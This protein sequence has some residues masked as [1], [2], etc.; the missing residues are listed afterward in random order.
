MTVDMFLFLDQGRI[1][2]AKAAA[3]GRDPKA[4]AWLLNERPNLPQDEDDNEGGNPMTDAPNQIA[5]ARSRQIW[6]ARWW[7]IERYLQKTV[8]LW[9]AL[10]AGIWAIYQFTDVRDRAARAAIIEAQKP[11]LALQLRTYEKF[12]ISLGDLLTFP[13]HVNGPDG[14]THSGA[15]E[16]EFSQMLVEFM[17]M[18]RTLLPFVEHQSIAEA[19]RELKNAL[20]DYTASTIRDPSLRDDRNRKHDALKDAAERFSKA[21]RD[22]IQ[23]SWGT[24]PPKSS[25]VPGSPHA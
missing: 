18:Y 6:R 22:A 20:D 2:T 7:R 12:L 13:R 15:K 1:A 23:E 14:P 17:K 9:S 25:Y 21:V 5:R 4:P 16:D 19:K 3:P 10:A 11:F 24:K 8:L